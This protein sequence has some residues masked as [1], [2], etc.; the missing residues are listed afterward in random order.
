MAF[1][2]GWYIPRNYR[3]ISLIPNRM[4]FQPGR[5]Q[6]LWDA[7]SCIPAFLSCCGLYIGFTEG[8]ENRSSSSIWMDF[9][10]ATH[11]QCRGNVCLTASLLGVPMFSFTLAAQKSWWWMHSHEHWEKFVPR[12]HIV[13]LHVN[14]CLIFLLCD[15]LKSFLFLKITQSLH[16]SLSS[17]SQ[18]FYWMLHLAVAW[19][20]QCAALHEVLLT[21]FLLSPCIN[22]DL[23]QTFSPLPLEKVK[24][25]ASHAESNCL[26]SGCESIAL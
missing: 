1:M 10:A 4:I 7:E 23:R 15:W 3:N 24:A 26:Y 14:G 22:I 2:S 16:R 12:F 5:A 13:L 11:K 8:C 17:H 6:D 18:C 9:K 21:T 19:L 20:L 25:I